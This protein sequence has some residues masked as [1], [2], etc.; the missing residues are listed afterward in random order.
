MTVIV[1]HDTPAA[2]RG[3]L[4]RWFIEPQPN[5]FVGTLTRRTRDKTLEYIKR[6]AADIALLI[7]STENN[8]QGFKIEIYGEVRRRDAQLSGLWLVAE[9]WVEAEARPF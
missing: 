5:V 1:A 9:K 7:V 2:I 6:N 8:C 4:K 3:M